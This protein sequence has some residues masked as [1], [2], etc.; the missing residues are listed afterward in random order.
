TS[1]ET[2]TGTSIGGLR[3]GRATRGSTIRNT[4]EMRPMG[5]DKPRIGTVARLA[6]R[7]AH[8]ELVPAEAPAPQHDPAEG[9]LLPPVEPVS[10]EA[11]EQMP[12]ER[13][14]LGPGIGQ[15]PESAR[16]ISVAG[17]GPAAGPAP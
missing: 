8:L 2:L 14:T 11:T 6:E 15:V 13:K 1:T 12:V 16:G 4:E 9:L 10:A 5:T 7:A 17:I 3:L